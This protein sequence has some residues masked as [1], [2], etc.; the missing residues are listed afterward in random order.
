MPPT[1]GVIYLGRVKRA[2]HRRDA[3]NYAT[4]E[5]L[6][7]SDPNGTHWVGQVRDAISRFPKRG[8]VHWHDAPLDLQVGAVWQFSIDEHPSAERGDRFEQYQLEGPVE[9]IEV[10]D[11]RGWNDEAALQSAITGEGILLAAAPLARLT[12]LWLA[13][14][15]YV[16]PLLLK[17][18]AE[19]G[20][21]VLEAPV[22]NR[23]AARMPVWRLSGNEVTHVPIDGGR[24]FVSPQLDLGRSAGI[25]NWTPDMQVARSVLSRLRK[26]DPERV[27]AVGVTDNVFRE[28]LDHVE[29]GR[30]GSADPAVERARADRL[31]G[32]RDAIQRDITLLKEAG[33]ALLNTDAVRF[34]LEHQV[35][36]KV[37]EL[38]Q[39]RQSDIDAALAAST[40]KLARLRAEIASKQTQ[41]AE[42]DAAVRAKQDELQSVIASFD[43]EV[44]AKLKEFARRPEA[45]FADA[46]IM[47]A[48]LSPSLD[49]PANNDIPSTRAAPRAVAAEVQISSDAIAQ[50]SDAAAL[51]GAL[52]AHAVSK[53]LSIHSMLS[54]HASFIAGIVPVV[55]GSRGYELL[56][57]YASA[58]A[59]GRLH[60]VP[61]GTS[62]M[63]PQDLLG[64]FDSAS[65]RIM[66]S[67]TGLLDVM[68][69][70][71]RSGRLHLV[72]LE[73]FNRAAT[74]AYLAPILQVAAAG[75]AAD[76]AR[77]IPIAN[78]GV[79][80]DDDPYRGLS[81][82]AWPSNVLIACLPTDGTATL[83]VPASVLRFLSLVDADDRD[84]AP[85]PGVSP[86]DSATACSEITAAFWKDSVSA[87][88][89]PATPTMSGVAT[90]A[91]TLSIPSQ[92]MAD[93]MRIA[94]ILRVSGLPVSDATSLAVNATL[95][96]RSSV[97]TKVIE[98]AIRS[99][100]VG[101]LGWQTILSEALRLRN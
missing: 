38:V 20:R 89:V 99:T 101:M 9:P 37:R 87:S 54:V 75:R 88:Q 17:R 40:E 78:P 72:I 8:L 11:L 84:R 50:L 26:M 55:T 56:N 69:D 52:G 64:R 53:G 29:S 51:R 6:L 3:Y 85:T 94:E 33:E 48:L 32:V 31:R 58:V 35:E 49:K 59:G 67:A 73:G 63:E 18:A 100:G 27:K 76:S 34:E 5:P 60:W 42:L 97:G 2:P 16:G 14:G 44:A 25:Q 82:L 79:V 4:I 83:P 74:E 71:A 21:W 41:G 77:T 65:G 7:E 12:L 70:A 45:V 81:R 90:L 43:N 96:P 22:G 36:A 57:A 15:V 46:V 93:A 28:Y 61:V 47:R 10:L 62:T 92:D 13:S 23:D 19:D 95:I 30:M 66:P 24:W 80:S 68:N 39:E 1:T 98:E 91:R 86:S